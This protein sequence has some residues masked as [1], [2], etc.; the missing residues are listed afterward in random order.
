MKK[1]INFLIGIMLA[2]FVSPV[3]ADDLLSGSLAGNV[4]ETFGTGSSFWK[5][6]ILVDVILASAAAVKSK[7]P[8]VFAGVLV[9]SIVPG[10]LVGHLVFGA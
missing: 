1:R 7:N 10:Y 5:Y 4:K 9:T 6:F 3:M 2:W 8:M